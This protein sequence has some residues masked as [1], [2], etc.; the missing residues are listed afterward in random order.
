MLG[1]AVLFGSHFAP[2]G[3]RRRAATATRAFA[4]ALPRRGR[5]RLAFCIVPRGTG[6]HMRLAPA[7]T[8]G[9][10]AVCYGQTPMLVSSSTIMLSAS[11]RRRSSRE[12]TAA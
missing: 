6:A 4:V 9:N 3:T 1:L 12:A 5:G 10:T 7:A 2:H 11:G 8:N